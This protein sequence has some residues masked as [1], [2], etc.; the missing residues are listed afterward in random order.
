MAAVPAAEPGGSPARAGALGAC[1]EPPPC[2]FLFLPGSL[3]NKKHPAGQ[4]VLGRWYQPGLCISG[5]LYNIKE[6]I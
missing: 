5:S 2:G 4:R 3:K 1:Q 6:H